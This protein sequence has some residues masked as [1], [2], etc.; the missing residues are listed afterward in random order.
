MIGGPSR[1]FCRSSIRYVPPASTRTWRSATG[2][3][4]V[5][6]GKGGRFVPAVVDGLGAAVGPPEP[7][8]TADAGAGEPPVDA[9]GAAPIPGAWRRGVV[10][11]TA[12]SACEIVR[13]TAAAEA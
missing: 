5:A 2:P 12:T 3:N 4:E 13:V 8:A 9:D 11:Q 10:S 7:G 6:V 1:P